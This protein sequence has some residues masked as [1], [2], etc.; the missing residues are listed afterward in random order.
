MTAA[1]S[2]NKIV[3]G[4]L[5]LLRILIGWQFL[6]EGLIKLLDPIWSARSYLEGSRWIFGDIFRW[7]ASGTTGIQIVDF[8]NGWGLTAVGLALILG[9]FTRL[10]SWAGIIMLSMYY[11]AYPP[12]GGYNY[13]AV[14]EGSYLIVSKNLIELAALLVLAFTRSGNFFGLDMLRRKKK[15]GI[16]PEVTVKQEPVPEPVNKRRE[17]L[18][19]LAGLPFLAGFT[20]AFLKELS[21]PSADA[22]SGATLPKV[23][24]KHISELQGELPKGKLGNLEITRMIMGC[25]LI[26]GWAHARDLLYANTLFKAYNTNQKILETFH[27]AEMAG[28]NA[29]F[30]TNSDY[31]IFNRYLKL[32]N[33]KMKS[34]CQTY[35]KPDNF[36]GDIDQ[37]IGNGASTLY[38]QGGEGDRYVREG[39]VKKLGEA[40]E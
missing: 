14:A 8:L 33:G 7:I 1:I 13:G 35:L 24:Y 16:I 36:F 23:T 30:I 32:Y 26:G 39:N 34:I 9:L 19:G 31:P 21:K 22:I 12:F 10:A 25:N 6:Y 17:L 20:G 28:I 2:K 37:A 15:P 4:L 5:A 18:K 38:I 3:P 40:I 27:L 11:L 29:T